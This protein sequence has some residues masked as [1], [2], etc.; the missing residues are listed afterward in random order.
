MRWVSF[1]EL[2]RYLP[3][4]AFSTLQCALALL[5]GRGKRGT[6]CFQ[7]D[8]YTLSQLTILLFI[9]FLLRMLAGCAA[10]FMPYGNLHNEEGTAPRSLSNNKGSRLRT[11]NAQRGA[12]WAAGMFVQENLWIGLDQCSSSID[13]AQMPQGFMRWRD[14]ALLLRMTW[15][16]P[17]FCLQVSRN[18]YFNQ[19]AIT[20]I[21]I[22]CH[23]VTPGTLTLPGSWDFVTKDIILPFQVTWRVIYEGTIILHLVK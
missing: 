11:V 9:Y 1:I 18:V 22:D 7:Q 4:L 20:V 15:A 17:S 10:H 16:V 19:I 13:A 12:G 3:T 5:C 2:I 21:Y 14:P 23:L 6:S 8:V